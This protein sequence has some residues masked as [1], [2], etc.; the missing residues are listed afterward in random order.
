MPAYYAAD[1]RFEITQNGKPVSGAKIFTY[2]SGTN[3]LEPTFKDAAQTQL[4]TNP[5]ICDS[6]GRS[7]ILV[8]PAKTYDFVAQSP[9]GALI[10]RWN[11]YRSP[12]ADAI[13]IANQALAQVQQNLATMALGPSIASLVQLLTGQS[14]AAFTAPANGLYLFYATVEIGNIANSYNNVNLEIVGGTSKRM[15]RVGFATPCEVTSSNSIPLNLTTGQQ[16]RLTQ[17][18]AGQAAFIYDFSCVRLK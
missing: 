10:K 16:V 3:Q 6:Q 11:E 14:T 2:L 18:G 12:G 4:N 13:V 15:A 7:T 5:I 17:Q 1:G 8:D 9:S